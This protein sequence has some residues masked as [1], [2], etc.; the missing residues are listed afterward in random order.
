MNTKTYLKSALLIQAFLMLI[1][2]FAAA[3][4]T[5]FTEDFEAPFVNGAPPGWSKIYK[6]KTTPVDWA[7]WNGDIG[8]GDAAHGGSFNAI[9]YYPDDGDH[10]TYLIT[11]AIT[12]P[13][14]A[15]SVTLEFWHKQPNW[16]G[17]QDTLKVY[18]GTKSTGPW[19]LLENFTSDVD[20]WTRRTINLPLDINSPFHIAFLG[21]ARHGYGT[22][23]DDVRVFEGNGDIGQ[24]LSD[25]VI[26][27][28]AVV[29]GIADYK[30]ITDLQYCDND[31]REVGNALYAL[32][33][34]KK[35]NI[36]VLVNS[37]ATKE[38]IQAAFQD[39]ADA[40][41]ENDIC[42]F[43]FSGHGSAGPDVEPFDESD[44][45]DEFL[46]TYDSLPDSYDNDIS[47]DEFSDWFDALRT[48]KYA[49]FLDACHSG[50]QIKGLTSAIDIGAVKG[51]G[52]NVPQ[53][54]DGF[55]A[56]FTRVLGVKDLDD[57]G[58]GV[59]I[60]ACDDD[61][62]S[63]E[64]VLLRNGVFSYYL[65]E[66]L[67]GAADSDFDFSISAEECYEYLK[68][69]A[70]AFNP[71][72]H[73]QIYDAFTGELELSITNSF[74]SKCS[75]KAGKSIPSD[76]ITARGELTASTYTFDGVSSITVTIDSNNIDP[77]SFTFPVDEN[78]YKYGKFSYSKTV[79]GV[80]KTFKYNAY[81]RKFYFSASKIN[82]SGLDCPL[83]IQVQIGD[84][85]ITMRAD[86][87]AVN[88]KRPIPIKLL[89]GVTDSIRIDKIKVSHGITDQLTVKG[90]F[91]VENV[92]VNMV[93]SD[94]IAGLNE[95]TWTIPAGGFYSRKAKYA[96]KK[97]SATPDGIVNADFNFDSGAFKLTIK[98][99]TIS[100]DSGAGNFFGL[101][102]PSYLYN[103]VVEVNLP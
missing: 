102:L 65:I 42:L 2:A 58:R 96:C 86:E 94:F 48:D 57:N 1:P 72:Q 91:S 61:E 100:A 46:C 60:T 44:D 19:T 75:V 12:F 66:A 62:T 69:R 54:G 67:R 87:S 3:A 56:D 30:D 74:I 5:F 76:S 81:T 71:D 47:D 31:A 90:G 24:T 25:D 59:V 97:A 80:K 43:F 63:L 79:D 34:W 32:G 78:T 9:L 88:G 39:M 20:D 89:M 18:Y 50:G 10:E 83:T 36:I 52:T 22:C 41:D 29:V 98:N 82:L 93:E 68:P 40:A 55:A 11:P 53:K 101:Q 27:C 14:S 15:L 21:N 26:N 33:N 35:E 7:R 6:T 84:F 37:A 103:E 49:V 85:D 13:A 92:D 38:N 77:C 73:A 70:L 17:D 99:T 45:Y 28:Y 8:V 64:S 23:V 16:A 51:L 4:T 95:Q